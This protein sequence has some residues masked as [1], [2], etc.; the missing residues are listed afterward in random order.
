MVS[1]FFLPFLVLATLGRLF[2]GL[3]YS[4]TYMNFRFP[5]NWQWQFAILTR[6]VVVFRSFDLCELIWQKV[7]DWSRRERGSNNS[8]S[9]SFIFSLD[10]NNWLVWF[11][12]FAFQMWRGLIYPSGNLRV[13]NGLVCLNF[14]LGSTRP[15]KKN[16]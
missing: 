9:R 1:S 14:F 8:L 13:L 10:I 16:R 6:F 3:L 15:E 7:E 11:N 2:W 5:T 12:V 4:V